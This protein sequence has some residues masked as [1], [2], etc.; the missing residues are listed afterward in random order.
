MFKMIFI[1][2][3]LTKPSMPGGKISNKS[4]Y[5][6][7]IAFLPLCVVPYIYHL[8]T[9]SQLFTILFL[10]SIFSLLE[11]KV[12]TVKKYYSSFNNINYLLCYWM[13]SRRPWLKSLFGQLSNLLCVDMENSNIKNNNMKKSKLKNTRTSNN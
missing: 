6:F 4:S 10:T 9:S 8:L 12:S 5:H 7:F 3:Y 11:L 2:N 1:C 13:L